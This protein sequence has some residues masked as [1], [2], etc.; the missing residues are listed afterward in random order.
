MTVVQ[1]WNN[2]DSGKQKAS[3]KNLSQ[4]HSVHHK[5]HVAY[6]G[7]KPRPP[8]REPTY[9]AMHTLRSSR[10][11]RSIIRELPSPV[12]AELVSQ[13]S[14]RQEEWNYAEQEVLL[15]I[16]LLDNAATAGLYNTEWQNDETINGDV[17]RVVKGTGRGLFWRMTLALAPMDRGN[18]EQSVRIIGRDKNRGPPKY[19]KQTIKHY[20]INFGMTFRH[21]GI[22][23][24][25]M[26]QRF[27]LYLKRSQCEELTTQSRQPSGI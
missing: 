20:K 7:S 9:A 14:A 13:A 1:R 3:E 27:H 5:P 6:P 8:R 4:L 16:S 26:E 17:E 10:F 18:H 23:Y 12:A 11:R 24:K 21:P 19:E 25:R 15:F 22:A 2:T